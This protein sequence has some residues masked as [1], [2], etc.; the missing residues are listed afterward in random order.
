MP[1]NPNTDNP[2][3]HPRLD[4]ESWE[5]AFESYDGFPGQ[6]LSLGFNLTVLKSYLTIEPLKIKKL[7]MDLMTQ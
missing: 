4:A 7:S 1:N 3:E 2:S 5:I 6:A